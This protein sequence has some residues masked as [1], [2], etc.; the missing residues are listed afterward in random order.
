MIKHP[1]L[2]NNM[3]IIHG[4][5]CKMQHFRLQQF[6]NL[7][8]IIFSTKKQQ[9]HKNYHLSVDYFKEKSKSFDHLQLVSHRFCPTKFIPMISFK[10]GHFTFIARIH[11][12][13]IYLHNQ[14][15]VI[16]AIDFLNYVVAGNGNGIQL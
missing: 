2:E 10:C 5:F 8:T 11:R 1:L 14:S 3:S 9:L 15:N 13:T 16:V 4:V 12:D 6:F 7:Q